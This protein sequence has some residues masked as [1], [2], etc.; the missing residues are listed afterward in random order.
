M[1]NYAVPSGSGMI[2]GVPSDD[3]I[4]QYNKCYITQKIGGREITVVGYMVDDCQL[5]FVA[6]WESPFENDSVGGVGAIEKTSS[7]VQTMSEKTSKTIWN[8]QE[9]W[10]GN[11]PPEL[12][13]TLRF[14]AYTNARTE[15]DDPIRYLSQMISPELEA[16]VPISSDGIGGRI[17]KEAAFNIGRKV[18]LPMRISNVAYNVNAPKTKDGHFAYNTVTIT[19][20]PKQM[21]NQSAIPNHF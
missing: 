10:Q 1:G 16:K 20:A 13:I 9:V 7:L 19:A 15:V 8:S 12:N 21:I 17:P 3:G 5:S 6:N 18:T 14:M 4:S 2:Y 11:L